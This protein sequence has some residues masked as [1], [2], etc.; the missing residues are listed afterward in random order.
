MQL[1]F[2]TDSVEEMVEYFKTHA[3]KKFKLVRK[4]V[5]ITP[6]TNGYTVGIFGK[7]AY[8]GKDEFQFDIYDYSFTEVVVNNFLQGLFEI[9]YHVFK[10]TGIREY[11]GP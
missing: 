9:V 5:N 2:V 1:I 3:L 10:R 11:S 4:H 8:W 6:F 7:K